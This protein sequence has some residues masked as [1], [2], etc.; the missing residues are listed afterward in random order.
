MEVTDYLNKR[1]TNINIRVSP[2]LK[3][4]LIREGAKLGINLSDYVNHALTMALEEPIKN[5]KGCLE[6]QEV[7]ELLRKQVNEF[8][9]LAKPYL[10]TLNEELEIK[11]KKYNPKSEYEIIKI[12]LFNFKINKNED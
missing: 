6:K 3:S 5:C 1:T 2:S 11:G 9:E 8:K 7:N 12:L 10:S 4:N